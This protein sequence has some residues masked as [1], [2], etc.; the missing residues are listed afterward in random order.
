MLDKKPLIS[1]IIPNRNHSRYLGEAIE[2]ALAQTYENIEIIICDNCSTDNSLEVAMKYLDRG[3]IINKNPINIINNNYSVLAS[4]AT[5]K[6]FI[7]LCADDI[8]KPSFIE[9]AVSIMEEHSNI[10]YVHCERDYIDETGNITELDPFFNCSFISSGES[11]LPI[12][13]LTEVGQAAQALIRRT[14]FDLVG[15]HDTETNH[16]NIDR[17]LWFR[18]SMVSDYAYIREKMSFIRVHNSSETAN[19]TEYFVHPLSIYVMIK[20]FIEWAKIKNYQKVLE[21]EKACLNKLALEMVIAGTNH[22]RGGKISLAKQHI[23]FASIVDNSIVENESYKKCLRIIDEGDLS[24]LDKSDIA[25]NRIVFHT[26]NYDP[27]ENYIRL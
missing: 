23:L 6:Y 25:D 13:M 9:R 22:L 12:Y 27:P 19:V 2:S 15:G 16:A 26:R 10:G 7:L 8:I 4:L 18:L 1:V 21:R 24:V 5:G 17:E 11:M 20:G 3:V 14:S